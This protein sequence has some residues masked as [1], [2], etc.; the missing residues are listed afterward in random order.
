MKQIGEMTL[1]ELRALKKG[2]CEKIESSVKEALEAFEAEYGIPVDV[3]DV[4]AE[5][6]VVKD[7]C[8]REIGHRYGVKADVVLKGTSI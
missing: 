8:G 1:N 6:D 2:L 3:R 5:R 7:T 4:W